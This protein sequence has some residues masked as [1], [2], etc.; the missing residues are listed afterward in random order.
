LERGE[1]LPFVHRAATCGAAFNDASLYRVAEAP[2]G[3][4]AFKTWECALERR[5]SCFSSVGAGDNRGGLQHV[6]LQL[7]Q[8]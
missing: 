8:R 6:R 2:L 3:W 5:N 1:L 7:A 4:E